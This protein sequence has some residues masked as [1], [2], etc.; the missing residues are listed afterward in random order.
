MET[1]FLVAAFNS[2]DWMPYVSGTTRLKLTQGKMAEAPLL[3]PPLNEQKRI[4]AKI[5]ALQARS[6]AAKEALDSISPLEQ[7]LVQRLTTDWPLRRLGDFIENVTTEVGSDWRNYPAV[8]LSNTGTIMERRERLGEKSASR[9]RLVE[10]GNVVFNPIRF[11]IGSIAR[12]YGSGPAIMSPEYCVVKTR[13]GL[14]AELLTRFLRSP[15]GRSLLEIQSTGSVRY[16]V[17]FKDLAAVEMPMA[18]PPMQAKAETFFK[19]LNEILGLRNEILAKLDALH[20]S[21]LAKAFRGELV[22]QDPNDEPASVLLE[23]IR[24]AREASDAGNT[25]ARRGRGARG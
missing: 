20:Q 23:R 2:F 16:R 9:C 14:S 7:L 13:P 19:A 11:S 17:Y 1:S 5:E 25:G 21:I 4:V 18:P 10:P 3:V 6:A 12:Y 8:G 22:P 15:A 24:K